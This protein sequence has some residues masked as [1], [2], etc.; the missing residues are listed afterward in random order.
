MQTKEEVEANVL[1]FEGKTISEELKS[2]VKNRS[3]KLHID[4]WC[5][6]CGECV[7]S[8]KSKAL[9]INEGKAEVDRDRCVLC[10]YCSTHCPDF[11]IKII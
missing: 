9:K 8:C 1:R 2:K 5:A 7:R 6:G 10:G 3:K 11:C 4:S